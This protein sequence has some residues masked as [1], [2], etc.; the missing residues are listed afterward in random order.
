MALLPE[1]AVFAFVTAAFYG[2]EPVLTKRGLAAGGT[3]LQSTLILLLVRMVLFWTALFAFAGFDGAFAGLTGL[4]V[5]LFAVASLVATALGRPAMYVGFDRVG[6]TVSNAF[7]NA[8]PLMSV[9]LGVALLGEQVT[10]SLAVGVVVLVGGLVAITLSEGGDV[11]GWSKAD[12]VFPLITAVAFSSGNVVRRYGFT[13]T[14]TTVLQAVAVGETVTFL[15]MVAYAYFGHSASIWTA[16]R[17]VYTYFLGGT[18]LASLGFLAMFAALEA[19]PVSVVDP[20]V[21]AAPLLTVAFAMVF[22]RDLERVTARLVVGVV[23]VVAGIVF[24][25]IQP[26]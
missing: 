18:L 25:T 14:E 26:F 19:G 3:W 15:A 8:R 2:L 24:V 10:L 6:S 7:V 21:A 22:L 9:V 4:G 5:A 23:L 17:T 16:G 20:I 13:V 12:L 1:F 11:S